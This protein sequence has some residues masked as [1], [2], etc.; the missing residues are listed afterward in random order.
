VVWYLVHVCIYYCYVFLLNW[1]FYQYVISLSCNF[2]CS[3][4]YYSG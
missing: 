1:S 3:K 4:V 2:H